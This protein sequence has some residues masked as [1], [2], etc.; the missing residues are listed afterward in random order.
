MKSVYNENGL[1]ESSET[2]MV[3]VFRSLLVYNTHC[4]TRGKCNNKIIDEI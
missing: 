3:D 4:I 2:T 1:T